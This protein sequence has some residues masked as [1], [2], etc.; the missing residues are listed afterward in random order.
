MYLDHLKATAQPAPAATAAPVS[1]SFM[2]CMDAALY[3]TEVCSAADPYLIKA[4]AEY[5]AKA[6]EDGDGAAKEGW[7]NKIKKVFQKIWDTL[8]NFYKKIAAFIK[9]RVIPHV[10]K[11]AKEIAVKFQ[12]IGMKSKI[13][14]CKD[15]DKSKLENVT[16]MEGTACEK[17][18]EDVINNINDRLEKNDLSSVDIKELMGKLP[19]REKSDCMKKIADESYENVKKIADNILN[20]NTAKDVLKKIDELAKTS[21]TKVA[22]HIKEAKGKIAAAEKAKD[23]AKAQEAINDLKS[24]RA[25]GTAVTVIMNHAGTL[26][27]SIILSQAVA[28]NKWCA[29]CSTKKEEKK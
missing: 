18:I 15:P 26:A 12:K 4:E 5:M 13:E 27:V 16:F 11:K 7:W 28:V 17:Q 23:E 22:S 29:A 25:F 9:D 14:K 3:C 19:S 20:G 10:V 24:V 6:T 1:V 21:A 2:D 8:Q